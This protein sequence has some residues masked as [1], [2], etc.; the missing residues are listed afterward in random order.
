[1]D[2]K[3]LATDLDGTLIPLNNNPQQHEAL[4]HIESRLAAHKL[5]LLFVTGR[6]FASV[7][8]AM[9]EYQLPQPDEIICDVGTTILSRSGNGCAFQIAEEYS[10]HLRTLVGDFPAA[11]LIQ[12]FANAASLRLQEP[13]KQGDYKVSFYTDAA[14]LKSVADD[15]Q[16]VLTNTAAPWSIIS[17]VDPFN[18]DGLIDLLPAGVS[19]A[20]AINWWAQRRNFQPSQVVFAGDS[21]NDTAALTAGYLAIIV[22]N[23]SPEVVEEV[24]AVH[25]TAPWNNR[26]FHSQK[27]ATSGVLNGLEH[28]LQA[29]AARHSDP[30]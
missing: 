12:Q 28:H 4:R 17:S 18:G 19:K 21:G 11:A 22:G 14:T 7:Q 25:K 29:R 1:M 3:A 26:F 27:H 9:A 20:Y 8:Q 30:T 2:I 5:S 10:Q 13:E 23:A 24:A 15:V 16:Q 6:H